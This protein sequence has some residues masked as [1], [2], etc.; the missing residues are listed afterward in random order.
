VDIE[1]G[2]TQRVDSESAAIDIV[3]GRQDAASVGQ[4][5]R[6]LP[7]WFGIDSSVLSYIDDAKTKPTYLAV[8]DG[9]VIG[10]LLET[11]HN[12]ASAEIH[13]LAVA[14]ERHRQGVGRALVAAFEDDLRAAGVQLLQ[15]KTQGP[16]MPDADYA[17]TLKFYLALGFIPLEE[18]H[19]VWPGHPCL[20]LVK[21]L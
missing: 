18:L 16:S 5:L 10:A 6:A 7:D 14:P 19:G 2:D 11:R 4:L 21:P 8:D 1:R 3:T 9:R 17:A 15:V 13:L 20:I 12:E